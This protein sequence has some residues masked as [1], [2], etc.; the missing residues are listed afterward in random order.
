MELDQEGEKLASQRQRLR[1]CLVSNC[2][3]EYLCVV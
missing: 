3:V 2:I 1:A